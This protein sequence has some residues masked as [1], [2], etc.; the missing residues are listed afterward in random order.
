MQ[1]DL[2]K[3][4]SNKWYRISYNTAISYQISETRKAFKH[5]TSG[6]QVRSYMFTCPFFALS[7]KQ[8]IC[9]SRNLRNK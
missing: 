4:V 6:F 5:E 1:D 2:Q 3:P 8:Y 9:I 7:L